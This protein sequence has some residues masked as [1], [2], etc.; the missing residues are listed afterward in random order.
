MLPD[1]IFIRRNI[2][3]CFGWSIVLILSIYIASAYSRRRESVMMVTGPSMLTDAFC[4][5]CITSL[6][7]NLFHEDSNFP[8]QN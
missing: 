5:L 1:I 3:S 8:I 2:L 6:I 7:A 4:T